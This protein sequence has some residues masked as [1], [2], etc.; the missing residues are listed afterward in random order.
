MTAQPRLSEKLVDAL[1]VRMQAIYGHLWGSRDPTP[2]VLIA[3]RAEWAYAL[4]DMSGDDLARGLRACAAELEQPPTLPTF[5]KLCRPVV[6]PAMH[7]PPPALPH[8][9]AKPETVAAAAAEVRNLSKD[10]PRRSVLNGGGWEG[11][12]RD[13]AEAKRH[14]MTEAEFI[15]QRLESNGFDMT[16]EAS[17]LRCGASIRYDVNSPLREGNT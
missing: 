12:Q 9:K 5:R 10:R 6:A 8:V 4:A 16:R 13:L 3:A 1:F 17:L 11:Y 14:G 15:R 7:R 2:A